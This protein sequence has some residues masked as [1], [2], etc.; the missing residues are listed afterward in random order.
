MGKEELI[1]NLQ[2]RSSC[3]GNFPRSTGVDGDQAESVRIWAGR[4]TIR[5]AWISVGFSTVNSLAINLPMKCEYPGAAP[6]E[7]Y[8]LS[9][10]VS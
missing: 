1:L 6:Q 9:F 7:I 5:P 8:V 10:E 2:C 3:N 4:C